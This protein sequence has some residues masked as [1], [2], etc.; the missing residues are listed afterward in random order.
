MRYYD[1]YMSRLRI[2]TIYDKDGITHTSTM[3]EWIF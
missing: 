3:S 2:R 1:D